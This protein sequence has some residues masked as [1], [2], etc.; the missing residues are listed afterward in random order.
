M[1]RNPGNSMDNYLSHYVGPAYGGPA[2]SLPVS[3]ASNTSRAS[4]HS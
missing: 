2:S 4:E 3:L 1:L